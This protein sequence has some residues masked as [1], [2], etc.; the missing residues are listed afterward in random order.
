MMV[1]L[2]IALG[3]AF[4]AMA[5]FTVSSWSNR[6]FK[7]SPI[8]TLLVN[9]SGALALGIFVG[10][11]EGQLNVSSEVN[12]L[13]VTGLLGSYT[14]FSTL[15]Y[16]TFILVETEKPVLALLYAIGSLTAGLLAVLAGLGL[17]SLW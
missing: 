10:L 11:T 9:L 15:M 17:A 1:V 5:R 4:G 6:R 3:G 8:G 14:T 2:A 13:I 12:R 7:H 16:E